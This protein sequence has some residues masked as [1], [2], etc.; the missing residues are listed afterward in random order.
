MENKQYFTL[1]DFASQTSDGRIV[2]VV[3]EFQSG[4]TLFR[5]APWKE[6]THLDKDEGVFVKQDER[7]ARTKALALGDG[8]TFSKSSYYKRV[9]SL[10]SLGQAIAFDERTLE[11]QPNKGLYLEREIANMI[12]SFGNDVEYALLN[13][14]QDTDPR[15]PEGLLPKYSMLTD[16]Y[17]E[18][19]DTDGKGTGVFTPYVCLD[20]LGAKTDTTKDGK[21]SSIL[22]LYFNDVN[23]VSLLYPRGSSTIGF[24]YKVDD[25]YH[26]IMNA[27]G[28]QRR[29][30]NASID[31]NCGITVNNALSCTR[32]ANVDYT[33][34]TSLKTAMNLLFDAYDRMETYMKGSVYIL[35]TQEVVSA[36]RKLQYNNIYHTSLQGIQALNLKGQVVVDGDVFSVCHNMLHT[37]GRI[38]GVTA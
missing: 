8:Y 6:A 25:D 37:E 4:L 1:N 19:I 29:G 28:T 31:I 26:W 38:S 23:G 34:E 12:A 14:S 24:R 20:A 22:V 7:L 11:S 27:D 9:D 13:I 18:I 32:I 35:T 33:D 5:D 16:I 2:N 21:L 30:L 10:G 36:I 17:G 3:K 15:Y